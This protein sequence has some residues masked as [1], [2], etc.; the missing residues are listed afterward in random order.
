MIMFNR[1]K[2]HIFKYAITMAKFNNENG[3]FVHAYETNEYADMQCFLSHDKSL[4]YAIKDGDIVS[5]FKSPRSTIKGAMHHIMSHALENG[6]YKL[7]CFDGFLPK[8]YKQYGF[9]EY[10]RMQWMDEYAPSNWNY[11]KFGKPD[12]VFMSLQYSQQLHA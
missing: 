6:G 2:P 7:D 10:D 8:Q 9:V 12:V 3:E 4:G 1:V 11:E 5:V